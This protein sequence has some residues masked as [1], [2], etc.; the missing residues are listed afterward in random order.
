VARWAQQH[1]DTLVLEERRLK[2]LQ[3]LRQGVPPV[4]IA[5]RLAVTPQA[6]DYWK[7]RLETLGPDSLR[8]QPRRGRQ[9]FVPPTQL[10]SLP[11][12]LARGAQSFGYQTDLW[13]LRRIATVLEK[14][15]GVH[16][17]KSGA[18]VLLKRSGFS[19]QRP[20]RRA[21]EKDLAR[22]AHWKRYTW[23][24]LNKKPASDAP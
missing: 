5:R 13:T 15:W 10:A 4:E 2:G 7:R 21:R 19:W 22:V 14:E 12:I 20:S 24:R 9:P 8:A 1:R 6:V 23:P 18:W 3:L 16:Y 11:E 17:S